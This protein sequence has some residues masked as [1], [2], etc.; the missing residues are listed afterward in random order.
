[1]RLYASLTPEVWYVYRKGDILSF[2][3]Q[4]SAMSI[5]KCQ[6]ALIIR[7][8]FENGKKSLSC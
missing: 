3:L 6:L 1:M 8:K 5:N 2:A 7:E 4:R